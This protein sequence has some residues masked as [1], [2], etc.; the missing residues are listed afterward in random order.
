MLDRHLIEKLLVANGV[1]A[2]APDET[3]KSVL[4]SAKWNKDDVDTAIM[5]LRENTETHATRVDSVRKVFHSGDRLAPETIS[6][7][8]GIH[9]DVPTDHAHKRRT[10]FHLFD[11]MGII[12]LSVTLATVT[13]LGV[14]W[15]MSIGLF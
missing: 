6:S 7:L 12:I 13:V 4:I 3:I 9:V 8:L 15:H 10:G 5:V 14:M 2:N 1:D 11:A